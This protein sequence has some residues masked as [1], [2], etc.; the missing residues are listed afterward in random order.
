[1]SVQ[2][3]T[4]SDFVL[5][6]IAEDENA[7]MRAGFGYGIEWTSDTDSAEDWSVVHADAK[8]DMVGCEDRDVTQH[9]A[10]WDPARVLAECEAK[11]RIVSYADT[12]R[13]LDR[14]R[15]EMRTGDARV[16]LRAL[17]LSYADHPDYDQSWRP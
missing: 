6:R 5:A 12:M 3:L 9:I 13:Q 17:S 15:D 1:M 11:R 16:M 2:T 7:A 10:R 8:R 4:L 14:S